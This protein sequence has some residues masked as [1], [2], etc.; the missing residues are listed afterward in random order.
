MK[1]AKLFIVICSLLLLCGCAPGWLY[2]NTVTP[3]CTN[4]QNT[5]ALT[6]SSGNASLKQ[7]NIPRVPGSRTIWSSNAIYDAAKNAGI[8]TV[9]YC[10]RKQFSIVGGLWGQDGIVVYGE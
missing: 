3:Y 5:P 1:V 6:K 8:S 10:D 9:Y 7:I 4:M 2:T